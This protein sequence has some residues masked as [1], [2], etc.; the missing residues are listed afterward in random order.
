MY[1][2]GRD[3]FAV[4]DLVSRR[5]RMGTHLLSSCFGESLLSSGART[6]L[7]PTCCFVPLASGLF[8]PLVGICES[9]EQV[10]A[11]E[12]GTPR[13][14]V[15]RRICRSP[16][17]DDNFQGTISVVEIL[18]RISLFCFKG[19]STHEPFRGP[20]LGRASNRVLPAPLSQ[21]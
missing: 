1:L 10:L 14:F 21:S 5:G 11:R 16:V 7:L 13:R 17:Q 6:S 12:L 4:V 8:Y 19:Q 3:G 15:R 20:H 2:L 18:G 9:G